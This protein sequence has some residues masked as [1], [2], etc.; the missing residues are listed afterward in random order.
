MKPILQK[1]SVGDGLS[2][3]ELKQAIGFYEDL[4]EKLMAMGE[5]FH[6]AWHPIHMKLIQMKDWERNRKAKR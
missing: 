5:T 2:D 6:L 4:A 1:L 3:I